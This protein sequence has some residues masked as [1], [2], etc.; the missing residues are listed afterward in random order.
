MA[1]TGT[2]FLSAYSSSVVAYLLLAISFCSTSFLFSFFF[3]V[4]GLKVAV[5]GLS[6]ALRL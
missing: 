4:K 6:T 2:T 1:G 3:S 5:L